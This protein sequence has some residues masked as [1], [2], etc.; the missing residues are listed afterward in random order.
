M[1]DYM[2][3]K[4][5][6]QIEAGLNERE[7]LLQENDRLRSCVEFY[8]SLSNWC[9][10]Y[11]ANREQITMLDLEYIDNKLHGGKYARDILRDLK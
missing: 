11:Y 5:D 6:D 1:S 7:R 4:A 9:G 10:N 2:A 3:Q 8:A